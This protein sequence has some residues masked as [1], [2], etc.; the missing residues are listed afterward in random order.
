MAGCWSWLLVSALLAR[1]ELASAEAEFKT[2]RTALRTGDPAAAEQAVDR[3]AADAARAHRL[4][5][6]PLWWPVT[7]IPKA[8]APLLVLRETASIADSLTRDAVVPGIS[9][10]RTL[11]AAG[12]EGA[13]NAAPMLLRAEAAARRAHARAE[14]LPA[15][16][17]SSTADNARTRLDTLLSPLPR[18]LGA[19]ATA[20]RFAPD[21]GGMHAGPR[22]YLAVFQS[23]AESRG[24][25]GLPGAFALIRMDKGRPHFDRFV[26]NT[27]ID[28]I[29]ADPATVRALGRDYHARYDRFGTTELVGNSGMSPDFPSVAR[30]WAGMW[31]SYA[32]QQVDG[33]IAL[34]PQVLAS[35]LAVT[36]PA[37]LPDG[38]RLDAR[39]AVALTQ[40][41]AY[42]RYTSTPARKRFFLDVGR[43]AAARITAHEKSLLTP[44]GIDAL[45]SSVD[46]RR[47]LLWSAHPQMQRELERLGAAGSVPS[48]PGPYAGAVVNNAAA[49]KLDYYLDRSLTWHGGPTGQDGRRPVDVTVTLTNR[50]PRAGLPPYVTYRGDT[51]GPRSRPGD[52]R[53][54]LSYYATHGARLESATLDGRPVGI[55]TSVER[56]HPV[57]TVDVELAAGRDRVLTLGLSEPGVGAPEVLEQPLVRPSRVTVTTN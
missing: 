44:A 40:R 43:A 12:P 6:G 50:A 5:T 14:A 8:G 11:K 3:A 34:D 38:E 45:A 15:E 16:T 25:G 32:G 39:N 47:L 46:G 17:W 7:R 2:V 21:L 28:G 52:N 41:T 57:Y 22:R 36:G 20:A 48:G 55:E 26:S 31:R 42:A 18:A 19:A 54:L 37:Q 13:R 4:T 30:I 35:V 23:G 29:K 56:G 53:V 33:V 1:G 51:H 27:E 49:G 10:F 9:T 24:S